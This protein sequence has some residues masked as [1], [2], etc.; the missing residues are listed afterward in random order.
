MP[1]HIAIDAS[2]TT[3]AQR[4]GTENY[5][6]RLIQALLAL[7]SPHRFTLYFRD[8]PAPDLFESRANVIQHVLSFPRLWTHLRF[9]AALYHHRPDVTFVPAHSLPFSFPGHAVV[10]LHDLGYVHF[11]EAHPLRQRLYLDLTT[12]YSARRATL[13]LADSEATRRDL[14]AHYQ[15]DPRKMRVVYPGVEGIAR[16]SDAAMAAVRQKYSLPERYILF[17]GTLQPRKNIARLVEAYQM[18]RFQADSADQSVALVLAGRRGWLSDTLPLDAP[19]VIVPGYVADA[20]VA[21]MYSG[22]LALAFPSL[23]EGFGFPV[24]EAMRCGTPVLCSNTSSLPE[25]AG[26]AALTVDPLDVNA[27]RDGLA[28]L[29]ADPTLRADLVQ[30]GYPQAARFTWRAAAEGTLAAL[31]A[32]TQSSG[33]L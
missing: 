33:K 3:R 25:L 10:T 27:I 7:D 32:A 1:L 29:V 26:D 12:R 11:P 16:A 31:E 8:Q 4:T 13:I 20:D 6:L 15:V 5:A 19:G 21:V 2:R 22:A 28:R 9:A 17:L 23:Y 30:R 18:W 14:A 24:I